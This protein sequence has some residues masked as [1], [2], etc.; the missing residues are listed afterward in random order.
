MPRG[1]L[2]TLEEAVLGE[3]WVRG[4]IE[5]NVGQVRKG[6]MAEVMWFLEGEW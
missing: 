1:S 4:Q 3:E 5:E 2:L 6:E